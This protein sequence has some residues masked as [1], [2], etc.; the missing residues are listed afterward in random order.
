M[1]YKALAAQ[2]HDLFRGLERAHGTY[3]INTKD[4]LKLRGKAE[5]LVDQVTDD[6]WEDHLRGLR[7]IGI[8]PITDDAT[9]KWAAIDIDVYEGLDIAAMEQAI[10]E[11]KLPLVLCTTKSGGVHAYLFLKE[12]TPAALVREALTQW[13]YVLGHPGT[14]VFPKQSQLASQADVGNWIN[15]PYFGDTRYCIRNGKQI[16][17]D[18]FIIHA[19]SKAVDAYFIENF[20]LPTIEDLDG[21]PPCIQYLARTGIA[22]GDGRHNF[23]FDLAVYAIKRWPD[24]EWQAKVR[25][26]NR[27]FI[28]PS[29]KGRDLTSTIE[30]VRRRKSYF[31]KCK[32]IPI[33]GV[34]NKTLCK[35]CK[36]GIG[37]GEDDPGVMLKSLTQYLTDPPVWFLNIN[38]VN[39]EIQ[40][41][42]ILLSQAKFRQLCVEKVNMVPNRVKEPIWDGIIRQLLEEVEHVK[43]PPGASEADQI[44]ALIDRFCTDQFMGSHPEDL[45][46]GNAYR[47]E[48]LIYF[49]AQDLIKFLETERRTKV[50]KPVLWSQIKSHGGGSQRLTIKGKKIICWTLPRTTFT[51]QSEDFD[52]RISPSEF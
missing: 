40:D 28:K 12:W 35:E 32:D 21:A 9:V 7:G 42:A 27:K 30:S 18:E 45:L 44:W 41:T 48:A 52:V 36:F 5:T 23:L 2:F 10:E 39:V 29:L 46:N 1:D 14:E 34:C 50:N 16:L 6:L 3:L 24:G 49:R 13:A 8:V 31:Y 17:P 11:L 37:G 51:E 20:R 4:G 25:Q 47:D 38:G 26:F 22:Q 15:M 33:A 19:K 43:A